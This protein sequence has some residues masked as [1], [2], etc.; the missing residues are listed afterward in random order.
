MLIINRNSYFQVLAIC[1]WC[2]LAK[3]QSKDCNLR[4]GMA[5]KTTSD[6]TK[7]FWLQFRLAR[8]LNDY[9]YNSIISLNMSPEEYKE[10]CLPTCIFE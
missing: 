2:D 6:I 3:H 7:H 9:S 1:K 10:N 5:Y 4:K 8:Y